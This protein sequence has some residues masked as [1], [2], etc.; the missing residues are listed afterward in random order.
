MELD[1]FYVSLSYDFLKKKGCLGQY[2]STDSLP[3][4]L[5]P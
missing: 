2:D 4:P 3:Q 1:I 5:D